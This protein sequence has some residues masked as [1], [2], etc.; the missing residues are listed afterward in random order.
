[1]AELRRRSRARRRGRGGE[2]D[3]VVRDPDG[4][5]K[6]LTASAVKLFERNGYAATSVQSV[7]DDAGLT[8]GAFYHHFESKEDLLLEIHDAFID[9]QL[10]RA[11]EVVAAD[12]PVDELLRR[13][14]VEAL[15]EPL[16][17]YKAEI[18]IFIQERRFLS[19][20]VFRE[21][22]EK[23]D[24]F[25][26]YVVDLVARG[27][28]EGVFRPIGPPRLVAFGVIGMGAWAHSW[29]DTQGEMSAGEI[30]EMY[31]RILLDGLLPG[32]AAPPAAASSGRTA[33][34]R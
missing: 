13:F 20:E 4:T 19:E 28:D 27:M 34:T 11:R 33:Q 7:V 21:V 6:A 25:E 29:L 32:D 1:M 16:S 24:E 31:S 22:K 30:G 17:I 3:V 26:N 14:V 10:E 18:T 8:K 2:R 9:Y 5:L 23:R 15:L 12:L